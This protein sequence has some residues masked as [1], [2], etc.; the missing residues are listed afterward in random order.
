M[1]TWY[2][3]GEGSYNKAFRSDDGKEVLKIPKMGHATDTPERSVRLWNEIN[4]HIFPPARLVTVDGHQGWV[5]PYI[6][7][8]QS[9]DEEISAALI[10]IFNNS[11]RIV[12]D[13]ISKENFITTPEGQV[14][15][16]DIGLALQIDARE[17]DRFNTRQQSITSLEFWKNEHHKYLPLF[18]KYSTRYQKTIAT[19]KALLFIKSNRPD[20][21]NVNF[22]TEH[23]KLASGLA[24][25]YVQQMAISP[26][27]KP[28]PIVA[29]SLGILNEKKPITHS[30][31]RDSCVRKLKRYINSRGSLD[32]EGNFVP[33]TTTCVFRD[34]AL[35]AEKVGAAMHLLKKITHAGSIEEMQLAISLAQAQE[36]TKP[37]G[38]H[39]HHMKTILGQCALITAVQSPEKVITLEK[40][41]DNVEGYQPPVYD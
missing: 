3:L 35:T 1:T 16:V 11:G 20:I 14:V 22:L 10:K 17:S 26:I 18:D 39:T 30:N 41:Q 19:I 28:P 8:V 15:C 6:E 23:P 31:L 29:V 9:T 40:S 25:A 5:C 7:G 21:D 2:F 4:P 32:K 27:Q 34:I 33:S 36:D 12:V 37:E 24:T 13:A 38:Q